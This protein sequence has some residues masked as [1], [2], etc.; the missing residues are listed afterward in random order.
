ML[1]RPS[2]V[3]YTCHLLVRISTCKPSTQHQ[4]NVLSSKPGEDTQ[5]SSTTELA[6]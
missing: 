5:Y 2:F 6:R 1:M 3:K 4:S